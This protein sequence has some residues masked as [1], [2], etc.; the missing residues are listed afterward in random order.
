MAAESTAAAAAAPAGQAA[1]AA[2]PEPADT[3]AVWPAPAAVRRNWPDHTL[4]DSTQLVT[5]SPQTAA[6]AG[7]DVAQTVVAHLDIAA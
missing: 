3:V 5:P 2:V 4:V 1:A 7:N 6:V